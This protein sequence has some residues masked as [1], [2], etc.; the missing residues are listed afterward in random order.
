MSGG[1]GAEEINRG[2]YVVSS[3]ER[4]VS[5]GGR[6]HRVG[7][8]GWSPFHTSA[9]VPFVCSKAQLSGRSLETKA[10]HLSVVC[11]GLWCA[12]GEVSSAVNVN[13]YRGLQSQVRR[14]SEDG[15][16]PLSE[17]VGTSFSCGGLISPVRLV[18]KVTS[19][20][21]HGDLQVMDG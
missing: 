9:R 3:S 19:R 15:Y 2:G 11:G 13:L 4:S 7:Q 6:K 8:L 5:L 10:T 16:L 17:V 20:R 14:R 18:S 12:E 21:L 1:L